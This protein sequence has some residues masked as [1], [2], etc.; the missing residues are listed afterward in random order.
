MSS[1]SE[2][3]KDTGIWVLYGHTN[4][5]DMPIIKSLHYERLNRTKMALEKKF[6]EREFYIKQRDLHD[7]KIPD[8]NYLLCRNKTIIMTDPDRRTGLETGVSS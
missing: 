5:G 6:P 3:L 8:S 2:N 7:G 1:R 4:L